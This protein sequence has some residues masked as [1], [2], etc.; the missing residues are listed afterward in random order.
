MEDETV[1]LSRIR[2]DETIAL[3]RIRP[4]RYTGH[5]RETLPPPRWAV[6]CITLGACGVLYSCGYF[7]WMLWM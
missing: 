7:G 3:P 2:A 6:A 1:V 5:K 4:A